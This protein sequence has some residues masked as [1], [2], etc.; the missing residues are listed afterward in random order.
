MILK[1]LLFH[2]IEYWKKEKKNNYDS[3]RTTGVLL[4]MKLQ[5]PSIKYSKNFKYVLFTQNGVLAYTY[6]CS[7]YSNSI[8]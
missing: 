8:I 4:R 1:N 5:L 7:R 3:S 2:L 6:T